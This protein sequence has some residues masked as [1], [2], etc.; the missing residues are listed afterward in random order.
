MIVI[1]FRYFLIALFKGVFDYFQSFITSRIGYELVYR[2]RSEL[3]GHLQQLSLSFSC[4]GA[5]RRVAH[6][7]RQRY[8]TLKDVFAESALTFTSHLLTVVGMF[9]IMFT[10][11]WRMGLIVLPPFLSELRP[12]RSVSPDQGIRQNAARA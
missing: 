5:H 4:A 12:L 1:S 7:S 8:P 9:I 6:Q 3:F 10:L 11:N 2:L